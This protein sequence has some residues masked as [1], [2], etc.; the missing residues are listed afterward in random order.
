MRKILYLIPVLIL[1]AFVIT[2][3]PSDPSAQPKRKYSKHERIEGAI[4][5]RIF[6][7]HDVETGQIPYKKLFLAIQEAQRRVAQQGWSRNQSGS[8][9]TEAIWRERG[10]NNI[11][12]RTRSVLVD[13]SDP[14]R[15][16]VW[17]GGVS[18]GL[19]RTEDI[20]QSDP[21]WQKIGIHFTSTSIGDIAQDP[22]DHNV[23]YV[24][25]GESYTGDFQGVGIFKTT[26]DG[27]TW[28]LLPSTE[29]SNF[30]YIN[31]IYVHR[32]S[33]VYAATS[34][35]GLFKS[36]DGGQSWEKVLGTSLS[37]ASSNDIHDIVFNETNETFYASNDNSVFK[38][39]TGNR[40]EWTNIGTTQPGFPPNLNRVELAVC[41]SN[42][43]VMYVLGAIGNSASSTF[44][45]NDGG[46]TWATRSAPQIFAGQDFTNGQAWYDLE[47]AVDPAN[48]GR[49]LAGGVPLY[50]SQFQGISWS[51]SG[52]NIH[53]DH[54]FIHFDEK[55]PGRVYYGNDGGI[56]MSNN[57]GGNIINKNPG[58]VT[59]QFYCGAIHPEKGSPYVIGGTQDNNSL[60]ITEP[61]LSPA[62]SVWGGDGMFCFIDQTEP[63]IQ[64]VS[65]QF[66][67][68]GLS[69]DGG[70]DFGFGT[71]IDGSFVNRSYYDNDANILYGQINSGGYFRWNVNTGATEN[72]DIAGQ[73]INVSA[74]KVDPNVPNRVYFGASS[75]RVVR[76]DNAHQ[77]NPVS[78][79]L[80]AD[81][82]GNASVSSIYM[83][84]QTSDH[85]IVTMFNYG[86]SLDNVFVT[87]N[88]GSDWVSIEGDLPD[89]PVRW[90]L[91]DPADHDR[92]MIA[93]DAGIWTTD[94]VNGDQTHWQPSNPDNGMPAVRVD[95]LLLRESDKVVLAA[96]HGRGLMTTDVFSA[97]APV[98]ISQPIAYEG[99][100]LVIDGSQ[101]VNAQSF[102]WDLG[103][104]TTSDSEVINHTYNEPGTYTISLTINGILTETKTI[105]IL[106]Y[107]PA[108]YQQGT[109]DYAGDFESNPAHFAS[110]TVQGT[111]F[112]R[113]VSDK[114]GKD[115]AHSGTNAWVLGINESL[116]QNNTR[117]EFY[118]PQYDLS[119]PGLYELKFWTKYAI[120]NRNDG[121]QVEYS[122]DGGA[123]WLQLGTRDDPFWYNYL[124]L[125]LADGA[126]PVGKAYFTNAQLN[127][128]QYVKDISFLTGEPRV[129]FRYVFRSDDSEPAQGLVIDDFEVTKYEG[130][131]RTMI[132]VFE[133]NYTDEQEITVNW[134]TGIEYNADKFVLERSYTGF[135]FTDIG[136]LN[137]TG[138]ISTVAQNYQW[139]DH[140]LRN[141]IYYRVRAV[142]EDPDQTFTTDP[143]V[144]RR[145]VEPNIVHSVLT[146]PFSDR[147]Y[148]SFSS[149]I[150][151]EV[152]LRLFDASGRLMVDQKQL[153][154]SVAIE[155]DDLDFPPGIYF[156]SIQ[157]GEAEPTTY[158]MLTFGQ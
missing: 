115:G 71:A 73:N 32:N 138:V 54:H 56:W 128:V 51:E 154:G 153:P 11:G 4:Q 79:T 103:D 12:G 118:T 152:T 37:G 44:V 16:R 52:D 7:S 139:I 116:Y 151:D 127:W 24:G 94:D 34:V 59:T 27:E 143:I 155:I 13:E 39:T 45:S 60:Q 58:Y 100:P 69:T 36:L 106:P 9:L 149:I 114:V 93:T 77:G 47:L 82:P 84:R 72:V 132:T 131:L 121:F 49:L 8:S 95:M 157:I 129:S 150:Y 148:V 88:A 89:I 19:W 2:L 30:Q 15:N 134:T 119:V 41:P 145:E 29:N 78:G 28:T 156:L 26:D 142:N 104:N 6:T 120:Q 65:S 147:I 5:D 67:N 85:M 70:Q 1:T 17:V 144:V 76:V 135:D 122:I 81:L 83:D 99:Q 25:T 63:D 111:G 55:K 75:G 86:A 158:K 3:L 35:G 31:E 90:A 96:T 92:I 61:G 130:E 112:Q 33:D 98:I 97:P 101:S 57:S 136:Q 66:G 137:A 21:Q 87:Y 40:G 133:A 91:F 105:S 38:S 20:S 14:N 23:I 64:I 124:N 126:F 43:N 10:P 107:L 18:G 102:Q 110:Y 53:V 22:N 117:A 48:C 46:Q 146:N 109:V 123:S 140:S 68:Y 80:I 125:Q 62:N 74:V 113:G 108:P 50:E 42:P 141:V